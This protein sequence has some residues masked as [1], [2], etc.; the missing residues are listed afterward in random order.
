MV[1]KKRNNAWVQDY[2]FL[3]VPQPFE[4]ELLSSWL[5]RVAIE[6]RRQLPIFLT[7]FA[8]KEGN[9]ISRT[10]IDFLYDE[11]LFE[12][13]VNKSN[14]KKEDIFKMSLRS[15]EGYLFSC[16]D[17]LYP[18]LQIRKLTDKRTHNG[19]MYCPKCLAEDKIPYFRKKWRYQF[20]NACPKH[21]VFLTDRC[22][23]CYEKVNFSKI[24]HNKEI[25]ICHKCEKDFRENLVININSNFEYGLKAIS[26]FEK[27]LNDG[28]FIIDDEKINSLF[29]FESFTALRSLVDRKDEL[30]LKD[31]PLIEEYKT[32]C[33]KLEKYNSKKALSIQKEFLLT[34]L[35]FYLFEEFP[36]NLLKFV[37]DNKL[38]NRDFIHGFKDIT[39]WYKEII[40]KFIPMENKIGREINESEVLGAIKYLEGTGE[41]INI[42]N[43]AKIVGCHPSIHKEFNKIYKCINKSN[44]R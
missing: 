20:Y 7:L 28:Y 17:C 5:T 12:V 40:D 13:L 18:P 23:R 32:I 38:T 36:N 33:K 26:W 31:F 1:K 4:D 8:K 43:V 2:F 29:V 11:K 41:R 27:S 39:F 37:S 30:N 19:L 15:E 3:I 9:Q 34:S 21:K 35:V 6:H 25:C 22:W 14:L 24:K 42:I 16:N 44:K 10:D